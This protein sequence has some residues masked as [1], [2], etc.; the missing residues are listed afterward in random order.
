MNEGEEELGKKME[1]ERDRHSKKEKT[2][3]KKYTERMK[4]VG[5]EGGQEERGKSTFNLSLCY[6]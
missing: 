4:E 2:E 1:R 6:T 5:R 3:G